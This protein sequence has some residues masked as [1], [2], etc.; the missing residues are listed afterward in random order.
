MIKSKILLIFICLYSLPSF[1]KDDK[2]IVLIQ[3]E[4]FSM[5]LHS[6]LMDNSDIR[7]IELTNSCGSY[8][9]KA[10][11]K[12][13]IVGQYLEKYIDIHGS[14]GE[15][16]RSPLSFDPIIYIVELEGK[17]SG[18]EVISIL[19]SYD[20]VEDEHFFLKKVSYESFKKDIKKTESLDGY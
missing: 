2:L 16:C 1:S 14:I 12:D 8:K 15:W 18:Y 13:V 17:E 10:V 11:V 3:L 7:V 6:N 9:A 20:T 19:P 5:E 4:A